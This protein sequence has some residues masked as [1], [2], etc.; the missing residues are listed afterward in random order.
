MQVTGECSA[1]AQKSYK[2]EMLVFGIVMII[3]QDRPRDFLQNL[4][5][6]ALVCMGW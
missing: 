1:T 6:T 5:A 4:G 2:R 3:Q